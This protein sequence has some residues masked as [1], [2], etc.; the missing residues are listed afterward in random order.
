MKKKVLIKHLNRIPHFP[1]LLSLNPFCHSNNQINKYFTCEFTS[2]GFLDGNC[3][4]KTSKK[5]LSVGELWFVAKK[6]GE[7]NGIQ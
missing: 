2:L 3:K 5:N 4:M 1:A 6:E 7:K